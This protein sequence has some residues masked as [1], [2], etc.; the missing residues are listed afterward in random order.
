MKAKTFT[1]ISVLAI[2]AMAPFSPPVH[3]GMASGPATAPVGATLTVTPLSRS[4]GEGPGVRAGPVMFIQNIGQFAE[5]ARFQVR[6][7]DRTIWLAEDAIWITVLETPP[8]PSPTSGREILL[9]VDGGIEGGE[10]SRGVNLKM[11]FVGANPHPRLEPFNRLETHVS[12]FIGNDP[13]R[14]RADVPVWGGMRYKDLYPGIDLEFTGENGRLV[15]RLVSHQGADLSAV[16]LRVEGTESLALLPS[17]DVGRGAGG[18]GL[19][20]RTAVGDFTLPLLQA[21]AGDGSPLPRVGNEPAVQANEV[22]APFT[23]A[24]LL[25]SPSAQSSDLLYATF[26]GGSDDDQGYGIA[27]DASGAAYVTGWTDSSA[28]PTTAGAFDTSYNGHED[29]FVVKLNAAGSALAYATFLGG[30]S[31]DWGEGIAID[32]SGAVYVAGHTTSSDFPTMPGVFDRS[33]NGNGD[34][35]VVKLNAAGSALAYATFLGG[36]GADWCRGIA[37]DSSGA[38]YVTGWTDSSDFP[39]TAGAFDSSYNSGKDAF[40]VKVNAAGSALVY[41]T[42]LGGS[43]WDEGK[44]IVVDSSGAMYVTGYTWSSNFPTTPGAFDT[45]YNGEWDAFVVKL[46]MGGGGGTPTPTP[47]PTATPTST[48]TPTPTPTATPTAPTPYKVYLPL[49]LRIYR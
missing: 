13:A 34:A 24:P 40:V 28:F 14:W 1:I 27:V 6:G 8:Q 41:A 44:G 26:L 42:F 9:P 30:S 47:T 11:S 21:V 22:T 37:V 48:P 3:G 39:T 29:A 12:Y 25:P 32:S 49:V 31:D 35:F 15:Q 33:Y 7:G 4:A 38:A 17:P 5:G 19:R 45:S 20:L 10:P 18:E 16:R 23:S 36:S 43:D 46:E 2:L